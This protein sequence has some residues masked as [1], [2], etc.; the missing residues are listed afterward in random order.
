M[1]KQNS[2]LKP[3]MLDDLR[4]N[5][6]F[7]GTSPHVLLSILV[8]PHPVCPLSSSLPSP[9]EGLPRQYNSALAAPGISSL[10]VS[11]RSFCL[12]RMSSYGRPPRQYRVHRYVP[13]VLF[14]RLVSSSLLSLLEGSPGQYRV[15]RY[16]RHVLSRLLSP[17][18]LFLHEG[19]PRQY[20]VH[21]YV[22]HVL[23]CLLV[24]SRPFCPLMED[25][26]ANTKVR[27][28][29]LAYHP[30]LCLIVP[31]VSRGC[32]LMEDSAPIQGL[33]VRL[34]YRTFSSLFGQS[35]A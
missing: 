23:F 25:F 1:G 2:K 22:R 13:H 14:S 9:H 15:H 12:A 33:Q 19:S 18:L 8:S 17:S 31:S 5:T 35:L 20:R 6:E 28:L 30:S 7:T 26:R 27:R 24:F 32:P 11:H 29:P 4:A 21:R 10:L 34:T 16:V 3:E